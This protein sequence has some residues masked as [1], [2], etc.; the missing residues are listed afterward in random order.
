MN[1]SAVEYISVET[2]NRKSKQLI[3]YLTYRPWNGEIFE[4]EKYIKNLF[5]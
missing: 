4:V 3:L 1:S 5:P 2:V